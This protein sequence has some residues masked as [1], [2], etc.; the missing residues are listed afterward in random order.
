MSNEPQEILRAKVNME[1]SRI[2]WKELQR[3]FASG[4]AVKVSTKLD[5]VEVAMQMHED[6]KNQFEDWLASGMLGKVID[7]Q[8][9]AWLASDAEVWAVVVSPWVLVQEVVDSEK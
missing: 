7:E 9:A 6:N 2:E 8:A 3:F 5:L 1:T 4:A